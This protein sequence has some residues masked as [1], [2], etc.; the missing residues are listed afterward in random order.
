M[1]ITSHRLKSTCVKGILMDE[2]GRYIVRARWTDERTGKRRKREKIVAG[3]L[4]QALVV[5]EEMVG[6]EET[7]EKPTRQR[8]SDYAEQWIEEHA[9]E[10]N[11]STRV[12]RNVAL[13]HAIIGLGDYYVDALETADIRRWKTNAI[14]EYSPSTINGWHRVVKQVLDQAVEDGLINKNPA[15]SVKALREGRTRGPRGTSLSLKDFNLFL[16][17]IQ[18]LK[19]N[20]LSED[21]ARLILM[22]AWTGLRKGEALALKWSDRSHEEIYVER[23]VWNRKEKATKTDDPRIIYVVEPLAMV[24]DEQRQWLL[25]EQH[26]GLESD[27]MFPA[28]PQHAK[29]GMS[30]RDGAAV[31]WYRSSS[32][33][34][35]PLKLIVDES[36]IPPISAHSLRRTWENLW[37]LA[38]VDKLVRSTQAGWRTETAQAIYAEVSP[39]ERKAAGSA[40]VELVG[41]AS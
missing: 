26:P 34:T 33:L 1:P 24:L 3:T 14:G 29:A 36:G 30:R 27:L 38:G 23:S 40:V 22:L 25:K 28:S 8:F 6:Q 32:V 16:D 41:R 10:V 15:R 12:Y 13:A 20:A 4:A 18:K 11:E 17:T 31:S 35:K 2:E 9:K 5:K 21:I 39:E 19:G 37:R 7:I